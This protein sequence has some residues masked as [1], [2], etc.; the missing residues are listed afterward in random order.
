MTTQLRDVGDMVEVTTVFGP[1][2]RREIPRAPVL[3]P[4]DDVGAIRAEIV[5]QAIAARVAV[6]LNPQPQE[7][8]V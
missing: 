8:V 5:K 3:V 4:R 6:G 7:P 2:R 1:G